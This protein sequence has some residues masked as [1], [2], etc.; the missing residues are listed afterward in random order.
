MIVA[1]SMKTDATLQVTAES[2][3][4]YIMALRHRT[5]PVHGIQFHPESILTPVGEKIIRNFLAQ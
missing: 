2:P 5:Y 4:G 1:Q 3:D